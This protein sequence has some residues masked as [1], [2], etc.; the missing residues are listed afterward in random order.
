MIKIDIKTLIQIVSE[1]AKHEL[2]PRFAKVSRQFKIDGSIVTE[3]D[4]IT[5][6]RLCEQLLKNWPDTV[7][8]GEEMTTEEQATALASDKPVWCIDPLDGTSNFSAGIPYFA[9]SIS[10]IHHGKV[11]L[12]L[13][14]DPIRDEC[15][16]AQNNADSKIIA[17][18]NDTPLT[19]NNTPIDLN[20]SI[21]IIDFKRLSNQLASRI[22]TEKP[23]ASQ[24]NFGASALDWC[25]L[26]TGRGQVYL[27]GSQNL[28]DYAAGEFIFRANGGISSTLDGEPV[29]MHTLQKRSV[30]AAVNEDLFTEWSH[31][32][33]IRA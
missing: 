31:W 24:R 18:L 19:R 16:F 8:L 10:L 32:L 25:W 6:Q 1:I 12:G 29:Y 27:H 7:F 17:Y 14:Y 5:Q 22:V 2:L 11:V 33:G 4:I 20:K 21:A 30:I 26:A 28:W 23:F 9:I 3:A 13:V 15:F